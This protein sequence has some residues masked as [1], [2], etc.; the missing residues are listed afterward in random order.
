MAY[1]HL[2]DDRVALAASEIWP[3]PDEMT[4]AGQTARA[5]A[6]NAYCFV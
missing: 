4:D 1:G 5:L 6:V 2:V 3:W